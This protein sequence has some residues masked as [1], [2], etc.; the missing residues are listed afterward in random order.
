MFWAWERPVDLRRLPA[1]AG[2]AFLAV[3][4]ELRGEKV[5]VTPRLQP[6]LTPPGVYRMAVVRIQSAHPEFSPKQRDVVVKAIS[7]AA[8]VT[9]AE[10]TQIDYDALASERPFYAAVLQRVRSALGPRHFLSITALVSWCHEGSWL[11]GLPV[12][13]VVP[14]TFEMG[15]DTAA[16][17]TL[18]RSGGKF[19]N[20]VCRDSIG[21]STRELAVRQR[22]ARRTYVFSYDD[23]DEKSTRLVLD[24]FP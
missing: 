1:R 19:E 9:H 10:A 2:V 12:D 20:A 11:T 23:W 14:M 24:R 6:L 18:L 3:T 5:R 22:G 4:V 8:R 21:I 16:V 17:E 15:A 7:E 13:E